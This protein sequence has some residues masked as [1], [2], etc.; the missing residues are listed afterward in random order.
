MKSQKEIFVNNPD[1]QFKY[2]SLITSLYVAFQLI[3]DATAGKLISL[4]GHTVSVTVIY[5]P[6]TF[7][8]ADVLT[9]VYGYARARR[10][11]WTVMLCS[12][13]AG[14]LYGLVSVIPPAPGFDANAAYQRV[15]GVVP[16]VLFGGWVA[17]FAGEITNNF[18]MARLKVNFNGKYLW[19][20]TITSTIAGQLVNTAV[21]YMIGL[22]GILPSNILL[23]AIITGWILKV[24]VEVVATPVTYQIVSWLKKV[25]NV[26]YYDRATNFNPFVINE[27]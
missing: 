6:I 10:T 5:F 13:I 11:L 17:V 1:R 23:E 7:I 26:D 12:I 8:F 25:E 16:R 24:I 19:L 20:R 15:F 14:C 2:L 22:Y 9:E 21:F 27:E 3:S 18:I 4:F